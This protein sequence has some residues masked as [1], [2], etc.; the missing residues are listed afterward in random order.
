MRRTLPLWQRIFRPPPPPPPP[1]NLVQINNATFF[2]DLVGA[3]EDDSA[4]S[5]QQ[6]FRELTFNIPAT[7]EKKR[8]KPRTAPHWGI[9]GTSGVT[10]FLE[11]LRGFHLCSPPTARTFPYLSSE[12]VARRDHRLRIPS[13][14]IQHVGFHGGKGRGPGSGI[15]GAYLSARYE[16]RREDTDWSLLQYLKGET[17]LNPA[18]GQ[19][20]AKQDEKLLARVVADLRLERLLDMPVSNLS[21]G[22]TRRVRIAK[23]LMEKPELLLLDQPFSRSIGF[24]SCWQFLLT[25]SSGT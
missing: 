9:I 19:Q 7:P 21:N 16:S 18:E 10:T 20:K 5:K 12:E 25:D 4:A 23:A 8:N 15:Q 22:Q 11:I 2:R 13:R 14:A 17:E 1:P 3:E 24:T 6:L